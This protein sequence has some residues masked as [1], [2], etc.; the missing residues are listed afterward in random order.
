MLR[1]IQSLSRAKSLTD[2]LP[3]CSFLSGY[4][5][6]EVMRR[7]LAEYSHPGLRLA[8]LHTGGHADRKAIA[9]RIAPVI[10]LKL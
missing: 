3:V 6:N 9:R 7:F 2:G 5:G 4:K 1:C 10:R 8:T